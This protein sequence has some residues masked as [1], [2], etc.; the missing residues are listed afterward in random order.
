MEMAFFL[1]LFILSTVYLFIYLFCV[2]VDGIA[3]ASVTGDRVHGSIWAARWPWL[4]SG[5]LVT[6]KDRNTSCSP[7]CSCWHQ[8]LVMLVMQPAF[9]VWMGLSIHPFFPCSLACIWTCLE[10]LQPHHLHVWAT[11]HLV[12]I[13]SH[14]SEAEK[15]PWPLFTDGSLSQ[16]D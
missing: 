2:C 13:C 16:R 8:D 10:N 9:Q 12:S 4:W 15:W 5:E 11:H 3:V 7:T 6:Q 14:L 1:S